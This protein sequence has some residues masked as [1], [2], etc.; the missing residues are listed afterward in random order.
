MTAEE[1][2]RRDQEERSA[3]FAEIDLI[4]VNQV[5]NFPERPLNVACGRGLIDEV[6]ALVEAGANINAAGEMGATPL[7]NAVSSGNIEVVRCIFD[8]GGS[9]DKKIELGHTPV[10]IANL[11]SRDRIIRLL[12]SNLLCHEVLG[13]A[14]LEADARGSGD[15]GSSPLFSVG[16]TYAGTC[17]SSSAVLGCGLLGGV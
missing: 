12:E 13:G 2:L 16:L 17:K 1:V 11:Y 5:G 10:D 6:R 7:H 8:H 3:A 15:G 4:D 9:T 14:R